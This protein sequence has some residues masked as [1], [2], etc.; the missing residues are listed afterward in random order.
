MV[1]S[2]GPS[3]SPV[4]LSQTGEPPT[5][6]F[7]SLLGLVLGSAHS[8][9]KDLIAATVTLYSE[10][11]SRSNFATVGVSNE[12]G[13]RLDDV[14]YRVGDG[15]CVRCTH[16]GEELL[17]ELPFA[18]WEELS[19]RAETSGVMSAWSMPLVKNPKVAASLNLYLA[20]SASSVRQG[21][22]WAGSQ[23]LAHDA[24]KVLTAW[25]AFN[26]MRNANA[27]LRI[28]LESRT[29]IGQAE[30]VLMARQDI[31]ADEAFDI[32]RR[33]SQ[34][35]NRKVRD[36][37]ADIIAP[38]SHAVHGRAVPEHHRVDRHTTGVYH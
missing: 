7:L 26:D 4:D 24:A 25:A 16:S 12:V 18:D 9:V 15:P 22:N 33:T 36:V 31:S 11:E 20:S 17:V 2:V 6:S 5:P 23:G 37:A 30:G 29:M 8:R 34:R 14:Q 13:R 21:D 1:Q 27:N 35:S 3:Q 38:Y 19:A 10:G 32:L 28:A